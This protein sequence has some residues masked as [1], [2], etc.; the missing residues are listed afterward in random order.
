MTNFYCPS[1]SE[2]QGIALDHLDRPAVVANQA[3]WHISDGV[4][5]QPCIV[6]SAELVMAL[7]ARLLFRHSFQVVAWEV[8]DGAEEV[9]LPVMTSAQAIPDLDDPLRYLPASL[10]PVRDVVAETVDLVRQI[11]S[12]PLRCIVERVF[13]RRDVTESFWT[14]PASARHHHAVPGGLAVHSLEVAQD[15]AGQGALNDCERD[16]CIAAGLLHDIGKVW[17]YTSDMFQTTEARATGHELLGLVRLHEELSMLCTEWP[18]GA[19]SMRALLSGN[20][21]MR[22]DGSM[23][24]ALIARLKAADQ[25]SCEQDR[26]RRDPAGVWVPRAWTGGVDPVQRLRSECISNEPF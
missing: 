9:P 16:L 18:E 15:L 11:N 19:Y 2:V 10:C 23:P 25:R 24:T 8:D 3:V 5:S 13:L 20:T 26:S 12:E 7:R 1:I 21:R 14:M 22:Q 4:L 6:P 17:S